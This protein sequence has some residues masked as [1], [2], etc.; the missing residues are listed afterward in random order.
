M[1][2]TN[3]IPDTLVEGLEGITQAKSGS[4]ICKGC[5]YALATVII[6]VAMFALTLEKGGW[7]EMCL[8]C[9][10]I[11]T[12]IMTF[13]SFFGT[14]PQLK[15]NGVKLDGY[16]IFFKNPSIVEV[17]RMIENRDAKGLRN[18]MNDCDNGLRMNVIVSE[19][20]DVMRYRMYK[21]EPFE[22]KPEGEIVNID[23]ETA[24]FIAGL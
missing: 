12:L 24:R 1:K 21:Y 9:M 8:G 23:A 14:R 16:E 10:G 22:Y 3:H 20:H 11:I 6:A 2:T 4:A 7:I 13:V 18:A 17:T 19:N 5:I 15:I